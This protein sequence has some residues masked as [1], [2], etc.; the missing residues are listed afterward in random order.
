MNKIKTKSFTLIEIL[1]VIIVIAVLSSFVVVVLNS[2]LNSGKDTKR[3]KDL[4]SI[5]KVLMEYGILTGSYPVE[6]SDCDIG[7]GTCL[8]ELVP[9]YTK[10]F[11]V[12]PDGTTRYTYNSDGTTYTIKSTLSAGGGSGERIWLS[13]DRKKL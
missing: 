8:D 1:T 6:A 3:K 13:L 11:P 7:D 4:D 2:V 10:T 9:D 12:D 5:S